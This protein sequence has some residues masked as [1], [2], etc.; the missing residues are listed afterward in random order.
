MAS[1]RR[2]GL[3]LVL[4]VAVMGLCA[5]VG[6]I[7]C[8]V[9]ED[10]APAGQNPDAQGAKLDLSQSGV[11]R[12]GLWEYQF[13][14]TG[15]GTKSQGTAGAL[16]FAGKPVE[17]P[18]VEGD[19]YRTPWGDIQWVGRPP[20]P[21]Q[22]HGWM[23]RPAAAKGGTM[24]PEPWRMAGGPVVMMLVLCAADTAE[25]PGTVPAWVAEQMTQLGVKTFTVARDWQPLNDQATTIEDT[26]LT[27]ALRARLAPA[28]ETATLCVQLDGS[29]VARV[30]L[31]REDGA[32]KLVRHTIGSSMKVTNFYLAFRV[33]RAARSWARPLDV[34]PESDGKTV[35]VKGTREVILALPGDRDSGLV[36][37][38]KSIQGD[39][40][41]GANVQAAGT[42]QF[43]S[44]AA[45][46]PGK[47]REG[48]FENSLRVVGTGKSDVELEYKR[49]WQTDTPAQKTFR[50]TLDV[51]DVP[52]LPAP[53]PA[54][55][56]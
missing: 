46:P 35:V 42:P 41:L 28:R 16:F 51:Q 20:L 27:G 56:P 29:S 11:F 22:P 21:W 26:K 12:S 31:P 34:G 19:F 30:D 24:L 54:P 47:S 14:I 15:K 39:S 32:T 50:V 40:P 25:K 36:W 4:G 49:P 38:I 1:N 37:V 23:L 33:D 3:N 52:P 7:G 10:A 44:G 6:R 9:A 45:P 5:A 48:T 13:T 18:G 43:V 8:A 53:A 55:K 2:Q 17:E